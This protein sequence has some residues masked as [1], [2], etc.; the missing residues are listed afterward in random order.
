LANARNYHVAAKEEESGLV[1]YHQVLE[2]AASK[3]YGLEVS[4]LAGLPEQV[5]KRAQAIFAGLE[6]KQNNSSE[7]IIAEL[8]NQDLSQISPLE[9][10]NFLHQLQQKAYQK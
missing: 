3:S 8:L 5:L 9:A 7:K 4:R 2:G 6:Q 10:L 1:F